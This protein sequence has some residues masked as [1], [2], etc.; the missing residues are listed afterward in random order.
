MSFSRQCGRRA[1]V[2]LRGFSTSSCLR[3][4]PES[5]NFVEVPRTIQPD[6]PQKLR[7]KGTLPVPREIFPRRRIDKPGKAYIEAVTPRSANQDPIGLDEPHAEYREWKR[8]HADMRRKNL[9]EG[10]LELHSRKQRT[11]SKM[12][13]RSQFKQMLRERVLRQPERDDERL[14]QP[15]I[16]A[17]MQ[18]RT[19]T[20]ALPD[21]DRE[22]RLAASLLRL[23]Q[24]NLEKELDRR[25]SLHTLY[26]NARKFIVNEDQLTAEI[27]KVFPEKDNEAWQSDSRQG[28]NI[29]NLGFPT[30]MAKRLS[31]SKTGTG[32][33]DT[34]Q[35]RVKKLGEE[36]TGG[37]I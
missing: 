22:E 35:G 2:Q 23:E 19:S 31:D 29:W 28:E 5:P 3:V 17:I 1:A 25:D 27:E 33:W 21:P 20:G 10:L 37:K 6:L 24:K 11:D 7:V 12:E 34:I 14:T 8:E 36:I 16:P 26:M 32:R 9:Q 13:Q 15:S 18:P 30:G 4:G